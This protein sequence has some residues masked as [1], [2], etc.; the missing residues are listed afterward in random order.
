MKIENLDS[1]EKEE[2]LR[3]FFHW[4]PLDRRA[5]LMRRYPQHYNKLVDDEAEAGEPLLTVV[6]RARAADEHN[7]AV[8]AHPVRKP[9]CER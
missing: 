4:L 5:E 9:K 6:Q 3:W 2:L 7:A 1:L 8:P